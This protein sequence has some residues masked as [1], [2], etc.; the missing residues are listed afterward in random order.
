MPAN[1]PPEARAKW[2]RVMEAKT[3]EEKLRALEEFLSA[4]PKHKGT[5]NLVHWARRRMAQLRRELEVRRAK[6]RMIRAGRSTYLLSKEGDAQLVLVGP[7]SSGKSSLLKCLTN[8]KVEPDDIPYSTTDPIPGMF[9]QD[10]VYF[11]LVKAPSMNLDNAEADQNSLA[12]ALARNADG[13]LLILD[14]L[15]DPLREFKRIEEI[16]KDNGIYLTKPRSLVKVERTMSGGIQVIGKLSGCTVEDVKRLLMSYG[17]SS[18]VVTIEGEAE[19]TD[20]ED[21]IIREWVY[22]PSMVMLTKLDL[23]DKEYAEAII[24]ALSA[25]VPCIAV[26]LNRCS[27]DRGR[28]CEFL[29]SILDM[30]RVYTKEPWS[31]TYSRKPYL[32]RRGSTVG[33]LSRRIHDRLYE[34]FRYAKVWN[35]A[36]YPGNYKRVGLNYVL[37]DGDIVEIHSTI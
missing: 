36:D 34:G 15:S 18:A 1:L 13:V 31:N 23:V 33:D 14:I 19:L 7:P 26:S 28:L 20:I 25:K 30:I 35:I 4:V 8:A 6:E 27:I 32:L 11:Q 9:I 12:L 3:P 16:F 24:R 22:K 2:L 37:R 5:E 29:I 21:A 10:D 17:L